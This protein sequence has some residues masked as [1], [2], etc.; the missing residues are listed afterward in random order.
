[1]ASR[2]GGF[3]ALEVTGGPLKLFYYVLAASEERTPSQ[4]RHL[5]N[6]RVEIPDAEHPNGR[7]QGVFELKIDEPLPGVIIPR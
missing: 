6:I 3:A 1:V 2:L 7:L 5:W 4:D